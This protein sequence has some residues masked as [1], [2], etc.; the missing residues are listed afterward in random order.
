MQEILVCY[1]S[2]QWTTL[3]KEDSSLYLRHY[4]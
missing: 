1:S 4:E 2:E 3:V